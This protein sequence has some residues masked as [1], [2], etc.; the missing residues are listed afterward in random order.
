MQLAAALCQAY[1]TLAPANL[2][3]ESAN[4]KVPQAL[5]IDKVGQIKG[6][7]KAKPDERVE[8]KAKLK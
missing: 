1:V 6:K 3:L 5:N 4:D 2:K 8:S 7:K